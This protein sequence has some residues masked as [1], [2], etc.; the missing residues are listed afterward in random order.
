MS[1]I[2]WYYSTLFGNCFQINSG[3]DSDGNSIPIYKVFNLGE[4]NGLHLIIYLGEQ[5]DNLFYLQNSVGAR[6]FIHN[7]STL[8]L[9]S[10]GFNLQVGKTTNIEI[11]K[12]LSSSVPSPYSSCQNLDNYNSILYNFI[13]NSGNVYRQEDCMDL[14]YQMS[15]IAKCG[16]YDLESKRFTS[17]KPCYLN[18]EDYTCLADNFKEFINQVKNENCTKECPIECES[19]GFHLDMSY[20]DFPSMAYVRNYLNKNK[21]IGLILS[22]ILLM[23]K[24]FTRI[25]RKSIYK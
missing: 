1:E 9:D 18:E 13:K 24:M 2:K 3:K 5:L 12:E 19:E 25:L 16:C 11:R 14:C 10:E 15:T 8:P 4:D 20:D 21:K 23:R 22:L 6:I 7:E 17:D